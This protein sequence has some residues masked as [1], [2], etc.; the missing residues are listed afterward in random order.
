MKL[1]SSLRWLAGLAVTG[2]V[3]LAIASGGAADLLKSITDYRTTITKEAQEKA[4]DS[5][6][7]VDFAAI[8]SQVKA[9]AE[10]ALKG[11]EP[12]KVE[13]AEALDWA[14]IFNMAGRSKDTQVILASFLATAPDPRSSTKRSS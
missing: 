10:E 4:K 1:R 9:K 8:Q 3:G 11:V 14:K 5:K 6:T 13:P 2:I 7:P 12:A